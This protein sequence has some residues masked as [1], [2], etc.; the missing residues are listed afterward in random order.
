MHDRSSHPVSQGHWLPADARHHRNFLS[1]FIGH[2]DS[3]TASDL[4][5]VIRELEQTVERSTRLSMLFQLMLD[6]VP[7]GKQYLHDPSGEMPRIRDV[8]HLFQLLNHVL[9]T[10]P[11]W[12]DAAHGAG[13]VGV[14][15]NALL[16]WP[17]GTEAGFAVFQDPEVNRG[18]SIL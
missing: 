18:V 8:H 13:L 4:H 9:T 1:S 17:M 5:P 11:H 14:P 15:V 6:Q 2:V 10:A 3:K 7:R 16:D 12:T